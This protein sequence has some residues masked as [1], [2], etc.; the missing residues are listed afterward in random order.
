[1]KVRIYNRETFQS[2]FYLVN[3]IDFEENS[4]TL[5]L[6]DGYKLTFD[7]ATFQSYILA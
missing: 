1:M 3:D 2:F 4:V 5:T 7:N 6:E